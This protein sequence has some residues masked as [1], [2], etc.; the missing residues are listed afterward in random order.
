MAQRHRHAE[1][2]TSITAHIPVFSSRMPGNSMHD[3]SGRQNRVRDQRFHFPV[4]PDD[5]KMLAR[6]RAGPA[7]CMPW[8]S[9]VASSGGFDRD[10]K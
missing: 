6:L 9:M 8:C 5:R 2:M 4:V 7:C 10:A 1:S 3:F